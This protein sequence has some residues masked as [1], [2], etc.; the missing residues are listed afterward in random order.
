M[1]S[2]IGMNKLIFLCS[3]LIC[4]CNQLQFMFD[5]SSLNRIV[6]KYVQNNSHPF[7]TM[8]MENSKGLPIYNYTSI[9]QAF[10]P[11]YI[12]DENSLM[13]IWSMSKIVTISLFM[14]LVEDNIVYLDEPVAKYIPEFSNLYFATDSNGVALTLTESLKNVCPYELRPN[15]TKMTIRHL[16]NHEAGFYYASTQ[17][18]CINSAVAKVN[19][20]KA[21]NS[22]DLINRIAKLP[23]IQEPGDSHFYGTNTTILGLVAERATGTSLNT[24]ISSR[25]TELIGISGLKYNLEFNEN[26]LPRF[27]GKNDTLRF[28]KDG[29]FDIFGPDF[30]SNEADN[31]IFLGGEGMIATANGYCDFLRMLMNKGELNDKQFLNQETVEEII[32]PHTQLENKWG[33]NGYN[34]WV[35]SDTL[36]ILGIGDS[37]LW[38]GG[39]YEGTEFWIDSKRGFVGLKM[40][41][42]HPIPK[43][44]HEFYNEFR[45][46]V[47]RQIFAY[48]SKYGRKVQF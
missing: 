5:K 32:S 40:S 18:K 36:K 1:K 48:E 28:A 15:K 13:R 12:I 14:D 19:L 26:L 29:D 31:K 8:R 38:Q 7:I 34:L 27:S 42:L 22:D 6:T 3:I 45:G 46:E 24:L 33:Y 23:L 20:P 4:S 17:N 44:G 35:T 37:G 25:M 16:I 9:N 11:N 43:S 39:G 30:P 2:F 41:Q 47:Y 10:L 21:E